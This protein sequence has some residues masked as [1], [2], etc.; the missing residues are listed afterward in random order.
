MLQWQNIQQGLGFLLTENNPVIKHQTGSVQACCKSLWSVSV[1]C[2]DFCRGQ[3]S[4][5]V[6]SR[7]D[8]IGPSAE[9]LFLHFWKMDPVFC[10]ERPS[11]ERIY[12]Q[13]IKDFRNRL[14]NMLFSL[15]VPSHTPLSFMVVCFGCSPLMLICRSKDGDVIS[16]HL[17]AFDCHLCS[18]PAAEWQI[19]CVHSA[20]LQLNSMYSACRHTAGVTFNFA[21][22]RYQLHV[23]TLT[24]WQFDP[25]Y[26]ALCS[27]KVYVTSYRIASS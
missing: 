16:N 9:S 1:I 13:E 25:F 3:R 2:C 5:F 21:G 7:S 22:I 8:V 15:S 4:G 11:L 26:D 14:S 19:I 12:R 23:H 6:R 10:T 24:R 18:H 17:P 27:S 20:Y